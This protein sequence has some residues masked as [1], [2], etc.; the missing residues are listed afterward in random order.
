MRRAF[1]APALLAV[2]LAALTTTAAADP[3]DGAVIVDLA[4]R[5]PAHWREDTT[6]DWPLTPER[7]RRRMP[8]QCRTRG[9]YREHCQGAR[10]VPRPH[11]A[12]AERARRLG[13]GHRATVLQLMHARPFAEW[14]DAV[15]GLD[16]DPSL[17]FPV[18]D[19]HL[20]RG[21]GRTRR[22]AL[23]DRRH[24]GVDIGAP[25][26]APIVAA[27]GGLVAYADNELTGYGNVVM[28]LHQGGFTTFYAHCRRV[29][30][31]AGQRVERGQPIAEVGHTGF[32][33]APHLHFEWRQRGWARD[34]APQFRRRT[35]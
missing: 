26:G 28:L 31:F 16:P 9:G 25:E 32:A 15:A 6:V 13:L 35:R 29:L 12:A 21:F 20:G 27:R 30:V 8:P 14:L 34:P 23:A 18:P 33:P 24:W 17:T 5:V 3:R 4:E 10:L 11:G 22:G 7:W 2:T 19:G 1:V